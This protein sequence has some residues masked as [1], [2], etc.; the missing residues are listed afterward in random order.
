MVIFSISVSSPGLRWDMS[1]VLF[2]DQLESFTAA[3]AKSLQ[4]CPTLCD[5]IDGSPPGSPV[6]G[7][8]QAR[9]STDRPPLFLMPKFLPNIFNLVKTSVSSV[10]QPCLTLCNPMDCSTPGIP[11]HHQLLEFTQTHVH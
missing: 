4:S 8:L 2:R 5:P 3:I 6:S 10:A 9:T 1:G 7:I 11:V